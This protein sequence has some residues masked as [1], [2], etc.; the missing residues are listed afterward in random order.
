[1]KTAPGGWGAGTGGRARRRTPAAKATRGGELRGGEKGFCTG[2]QPGVGVRVREGGEGW[3]VRLLRG[4][5]LSTRVHI[6][7]S[8]RALVKNLPCGAGTR[9]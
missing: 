5:Q 2:R 8:G 6:R 9:V 3:E 1:M 7:D 4:D